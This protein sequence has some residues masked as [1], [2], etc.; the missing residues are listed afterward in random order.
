MN[1]LAM[2]RRVASP[3]LRHGLREHAR[4]LSKRLPICFQL[5]NAILRLIKV[6]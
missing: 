4:L 3:M 6:P 1:I 2:R 5:S